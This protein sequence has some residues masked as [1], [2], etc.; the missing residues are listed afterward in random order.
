MAMLVAVNDESMR[1]ANKAFRRLP[2]ELKNDLRKWQ[3]ASVTP[4]WKEEIEKTRSAAPALTAKAFK[5][6]TRVKAGA[7]ISLIAGGSKKKLSGGTTF[8]DI[9]KPL[10]FGSNRRNKYTKY[11]RRSTTGKLHQVVR[12]T[13]RQ[14]PTYRRGGYVVYPASKPA[15]K[16]LASLQVQ[17]VTRKIYE[18]AEGR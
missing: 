7:S 13:G 2:K 17:T 15:I 9:A 3:R 8:S 16:R 14:L 5:S 11:N 10:E 12:R 4:I 6:G 1:A 18:A